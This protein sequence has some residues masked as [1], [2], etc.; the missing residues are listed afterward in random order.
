MKTSKLF[1]LL[2]ALIYTTT[3]WA[4]TTTELTL[5]SPPMGASSTK[6]FHAQAYINN[7]KKIVI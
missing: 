3:A 6:N 4:Q 1:T 7:D 2:A 5:G